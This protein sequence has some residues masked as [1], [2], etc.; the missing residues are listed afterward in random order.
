M[1]LSTGFDSPIASIAKFVLRTAMKLN[2]QRLIS[3]EDFLSIHEGT[4]NP[5]SCHEQNYHLMVIDASCLK[6]FVFRSLFKKLRDMYL[7][8]KDRP[9]T[10]ILSFS[11]LVYLAVYEVS[12]A[13][14]KFN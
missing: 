12:A 8:N 13:K 6:R 1:A 3:H 4:Y 7:N 10:N 5:A 2:S 11:H 9:F 14:S